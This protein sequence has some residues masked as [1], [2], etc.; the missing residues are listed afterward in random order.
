[1]SVIIT[2]SKFAYSERKPDTVVATPDTSTTPDTGATPNA[3]AT[4]ATVTT[5]DV[6]TPDTGESDAETTEKE[7]VVVTKKKK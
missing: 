2:P 4:P 5:N 6:A 7:K 1:M 3:V